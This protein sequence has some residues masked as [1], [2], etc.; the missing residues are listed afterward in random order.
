MERE[1]TAVFNKTDEYFE[2][3]IGKEFQFTS[4]TGPYEYLLGSLSGCFY[5]TMQSFIEESIWDEVIIKVGG[6]KRKTSPTTLEL[7]RLEITAKGVSDKPKFEETVEWAKNNC[8]I[9]QTIS[10]VSKMELEIK[11]L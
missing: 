3:S 5:R 2:N 11:Y 6:N 10:Q 1:I 4:L 9:F 8:S 7:T